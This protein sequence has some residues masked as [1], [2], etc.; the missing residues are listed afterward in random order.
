MTSN[1]RPSVSSTEPDEK[2]SAIMRSVGRR[3][4]GPEM[5]VRSALHQM[6]FRFRLHDRRL[7]GSPDLILPKHRAVVFVH[8][9]FWHRHAGCRLATMPKTRVKFWSEKFAR[10]VKRDRDNLKALGSQG[11][12][13]AV[14]WQC[15]LSRG[16]R[17]RTIG[18]LAEWLKDAEPGFELKTRDSP[19]GPP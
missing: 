15:Q 1:E 4:T 5:I 10:N 3:D 17:D 14:V 8:G 6:G 18:A 19:L 13:T 2:R 9:C 7:P 16:S 12:R 11:W